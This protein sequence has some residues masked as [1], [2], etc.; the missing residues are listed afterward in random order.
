MAPI[1]RKLATLSKIMTEGMKLELAGFR[2]PVI[3]FLPEA[4]GRIRTVSDVEE[5]QLVRVALLKGDQDMAD[6]IVLSVDTGMRQGE[7]LKVTTGHAM[8]GM[9]LLTGAICKSKKGRTIPLTDRALAIWTRRAE[10]LPP[11]SRLFPDLTKAAIRHRWDRLLET[12]GIDDETLVPTPCGTRSAA[13][14][15]TSGPKPRTSRSW[16]ATP[17]LQ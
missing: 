4:E 14:W 16:P 3:D 15:P 10:S 2:K 13:G 6:Y 17:P 9:V 8:N 7:A 12:C 5:E 1:N 11:G